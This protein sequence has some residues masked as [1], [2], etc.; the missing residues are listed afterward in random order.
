MIKWY[1]DWESDRAHRQMAEEHYEEQHHE[2][3]WAL[4]TA[5]LFYVVIWLL[6]AAF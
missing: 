1:R 6:M 4:A 2:W 3:V 5:A